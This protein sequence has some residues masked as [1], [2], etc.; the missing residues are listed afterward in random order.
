MVLISH[1]LN[2]DNYNYISWNRYMM[3]ALNTKLKLGF[4]NGKIN[5]LTEDDECFS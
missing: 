3:L 1:P 4:I 2:G 5:Q